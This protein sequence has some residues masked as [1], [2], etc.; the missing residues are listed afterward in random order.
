MLQIHYRSI[1]VKVV[2][3]NVGLQV[4]DV[5]RPVLVWNSNKSVGLNRRSIYDNQIRTGTSVLCPPK[6]RP[7]TIVYAWLRCRCGGHRTSIRRRVI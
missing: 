7:M 5:N 3:C 6:Q 1:L 2:F 4:D